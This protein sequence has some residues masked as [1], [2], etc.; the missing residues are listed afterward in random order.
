MHLRNGIL[1]IIGGLLAAFSFP[2]P[3]CIDLNWHGGFLSFFSLIPLLAVREPSGPKYSWRWGFL[4]GFL[5]FGISIIWMAGMKS[6][7]PLGPLAWFLL[8]AYLAFYPALFLWAYHILLARGVPAWSAAMTLWISLEFLRNYFISGFPWVVFGYAHYQNPLL[9]AIAPVT[10]VWGLSLITVFINTVLYI[11]LAKQ[12]PCLQGQEIMI[13]KDEVN[14]IPRPL[15]RWVVWTLLLIFILCGAIYENVQLKRFPGSEPIQVGVLQGNIDQDQIWDQQYINKT[16][17]VYS[18]LV[19]Q[20]VLSGARL[21]VWP[22][23]AFP[24]IFN[25]DYQQAEV[26]REWSRQWNVTQLVGSDEV[27]TS[28]YEGYEYFNSILLLNTEGKLQGRTSK[29]HLVPFGEYVP[30]KNSVFFFIHKIVKRYGGAGFTPGKER[31]VL[32]WREGG[33]VIPAGALIC[34]ESLFPRYTVQLCR[35]GGE[36]LVVITN[37]TWFGKSAAPAQHAIFSALRAA[38]TGRYLLRAATTGISVIYNPQGRRLGFVALNKKGQLV[39]AIRP[40]QHLTLYTRF[41][42]WICWICLF[43]LCLDFLP[44]LREQFLRRINRSYCGIFQ[45]FWGKRL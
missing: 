18:E 15:F 42:N 9:M 8:T 17:A 21:L 39:K 31:S 7:S 33:R 32:K 19:Q 2:N 10:G 29:L 30:Y 6:M 37:D 16:F 24:G 28:E 4:Y 13:N 36:F 23:T 41:G 45:R 20:A 44:L 11:A 35:L 25:L 1:C 40:R 43:M 38:E 22:E 5:Y 26:V 14:P 27:K 12:I 34:F 3:L